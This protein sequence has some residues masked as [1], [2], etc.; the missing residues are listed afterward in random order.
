MRQVQLLILLAQSIDDFNLYLEDLTPIQKWV[1]WNVRVLDSYYLLSRY[2]NLDY[3][4]ECYRCVKED[5]SLENFMF[6][7]SLQCD[8]YHSNTEPMWV[9][10][11][12]FWIKSFCPTNFLYKLFWVL[13]SNEPKLKRLINNFRRQQRAKRLFKRL[14][15]IRQHG[16][17]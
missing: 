9:K 7:C 5:T 13:N 15:S 1:L 3:L 11:L 8:I 6:N 12:Y 17:T 2:R 16:Q 10:K 4:F 14:Q